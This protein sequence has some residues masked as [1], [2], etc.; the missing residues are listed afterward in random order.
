MEPDSAVALTRFFSWWRRTAPRT[1]HPSTSVSALDCLDVEGP[2]RVT[3]LAAAERITQ[4]GMSALVTRLAADGLVTRSTDP[5]DGRVALVDITAHG[6]QALVATRSARA[7]ELTRRLAMLTDTD[8][9]ALDAAVPALNR[10]TAGD[11][12]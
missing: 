4:P 10:L 11:T 2:Q 9:R 8:R 6:R 1:T 7:D 5:G 12:L 3:D